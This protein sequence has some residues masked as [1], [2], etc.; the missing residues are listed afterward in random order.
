M[1]SGDHVPKHACS[2][3]SSESGVAWPARISVHIIGY[4]GPVSSW[5]EFVW[6]KTQGVL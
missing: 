5:F 3:S 6:H 1:V 4:V 2:G